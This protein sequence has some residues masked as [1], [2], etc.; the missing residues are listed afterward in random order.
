MKYIVGQK[1]HKP[2][3]LG[4]GIMSAINNMPKVYLHDITLEQ[5]EEMFKSYKTKQ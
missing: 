5:I 4:D 1:T 3:K 2:I